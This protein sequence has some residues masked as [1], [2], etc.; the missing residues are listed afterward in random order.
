MLAN[1]LQGVLDFAVQS[2]EAAGELTLRH[3]QSGLG[4]DLKADQS[5]VT[6]ADREAEQL[7][8]ARIGQ[9]FPSHGVLGEEFGETRGAQ[10]V[11]WILD[12]IDG[13]FSFMQGVPLYSVL[14]G[15]EVR[16]AVLAGVMHFPALRET[17][18]AARGLGCWWNGRRCG[19]SDVPEL[20]Q[21]TF[22]YC[23]A[24]GFAQGG[25]ARLF[26]RVCEACQRDRGW[27]DAYAYALV[28]TGR[29]DL[30]LDPLMQ[31][32][33]NAALLPIVLEAGGGFT[34]WGGETTHASPNAVA[35]N[36]RLHAQ[37]LALIRAHAAPAPE[38]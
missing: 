21:A 2:A 35:T 33:D 3:F 19:V 31:I 8:R 24:K 18:C 36:G 13:T 11:R 1:E 37:A 9:A 30:A 27:S 28:A 6:I 34:D 20:S 5:P 38:N 10:P 17:I 25:H 23:S 12:P 29:A 26:E 22:V 14:I 16:G 15:V 7:L 32:W 4:H